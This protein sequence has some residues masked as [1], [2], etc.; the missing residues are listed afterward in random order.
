MPNG[1]ARR[2]AKVLTAAQVRTVQEP[3]SITTA[4]ALASSFAS[5][6]TARGS[7]YSGS[8]S[9]ASA[10]SSGLGSPPLVSLAEARETAIAHKKLVRD[11]GDPLAEKRKVAGR[12]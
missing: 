9:G 11:G 2:A 4:A 10:A 7:G 12:A 3:A 5:I 6:P 1:S 8:R